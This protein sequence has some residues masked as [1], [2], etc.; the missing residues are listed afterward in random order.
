MPLF[1]VLSFAFI[2]PPV[3]KRIVQEKQSG[4]KELMKMMGLPTWMNWVFYFFDAIVTLIISIIIMVVLI[5]VEWK[6]GEGRVIEF[7]DGSVVFFFFLIYA[8]SLVVFLFS[9]STVFSNRKFD[10]NYIRDA[11]LIFESFFQQTWPWQLAYLFILLDFW[12][13]LLWWM[14]R[15]TR[16]WVMRPK[17]YWRWFTPILAFCGVRKLWNL[18]KSPVKAYI[19]AICLTESNL[20]ILW[21]WDFCGFYFSSICWFLPL[22][23]GTLT[24]FIQDP[25]ELPK[26]GISAFR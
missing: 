14:T 3:L 26:S 13:L 1:M 24:Q 15:N 23:L 10:W 4:V 9:I 5:H 17:S 22:L 8:M 12:W 2:I 19:G 11:I 16:H 18:V 7:S 25:M 20:T 6:S 21:P